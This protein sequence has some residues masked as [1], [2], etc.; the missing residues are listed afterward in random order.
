ML[1]VIQNTFGRDFTLKR[2][3]ALDTNFY[4]TKTQIKN[5]I[6]I[7]KASEGGYSLDVLTIKNIALPS[8]TLKV[9]V[10]VTKNEIGLGCHVFRG[11]NLKK[12]LSWTR[13][14]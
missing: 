4:A 12:L 3:R 11:Q 9:S 6:K 14:P 7:A 1:I 5:A 8:S 13:R 2:D 10:S